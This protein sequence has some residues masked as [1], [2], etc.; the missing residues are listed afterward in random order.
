MLRL[1]CSSRRSRKAYSGFRYDADEFEE[2]GDDQVVVLGR[3]FA[4]ARA[5]GMPLFGDVRSHLDG[6][7]R[8]RFHVCHRDP[9]Q[10]RKAAAGS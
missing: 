7:R 8:P 9:E 5:T 1:G 2:I 10:A 4:R 3:I 6:S